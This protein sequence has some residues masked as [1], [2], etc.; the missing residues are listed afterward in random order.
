MS[1]SS[2][3]PHTYSGLD[4]SD[5]SLTPVV[6]RADIEA[7]LAAGK[8]LWDACKGKLDEVV[9]D[10]PLAR[11]RH[12]TVLGQN[13]R[14]LG[15]LSADYNVRIMVPHHESGHNVVQL[16]GDLGNVQKC[17]VDLLQVAS[18]K[19]GDTAV[20]TTI[21]V[22]WALSKR[23]LGLLRKTRCTIKKKSIDVDGKEHWQ[24]VI[25]A[26]HRDH[27]QAAVACCQKWTVSHQTNGRKGS[28]GATTEGAKGK[29]TPSKQNSATKAAKKIP[30]CGDNKAKAFREFDQS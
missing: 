16:E 18:R 3:I 11:H 24:L 12:S 30:R 14:T 20:S 9:L 27:V 23:K 13:G 7:A 21:V 2:A 4:F 22:P 28:S 6:I 17:L 26:F 15:K 5:P 8:C 29:G 10:I 25:S 19:A 1:P